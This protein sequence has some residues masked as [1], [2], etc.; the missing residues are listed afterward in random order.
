MYSSCYIKILI[1]YNSW[2]M[3]ICVYLFQNSFN[4]LHFF[5]REKSF[6]NFLVVEHFI[7]VLLSVNKFKNDVS[8]LI[9]IHKMYLR[10]VGQ[11]KQIQKLCRYGNVLTHCLV[12]KNRR[13]FLP[14][15]TFVYFF[16][17][18]IFNNFYIIVFA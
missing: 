11:K 13:K 17:L 12:L 16:N 9:L 8:N 14:P 4:V 18:L 7:G 1:L 2:Y 5:V 15:I 3:V 10:S 6:L